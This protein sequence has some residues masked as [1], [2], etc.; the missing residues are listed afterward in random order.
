VLHAPRV[1]LADDSRNPVEQLEDLRTANWI[2]HRAVDAQL[3]CIAPLLHNIV[4][5]TPSPETRETVGLLEIG[6]FHHDDA[7]ESVIEPVEVLDDTMNCRIIKN[8]GEG[9]GINVV[10]NKI[11]VL[12]MIRVLCLDSEEA[13]VLR[14]SAVERSRITLMREVNFVVVLVLQNKTHVLAKKE[15]VLNSV[16]VRNNKNI[17]GNLDFLRHY[18]IIHLLKRVEPN[19]FFST[20]STFEKVE[21]NNLGGAKPTIIN[22]G[23]APLFSKVES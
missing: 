16:S 18:I 13:N 22:K 3:E 12:V 8:L 9:D 15:F 7:S 20:F 1:L 2:E 11:N 4:L 14:R 5:H 6:T 17:L 21:P 19:S 23:L 10:E